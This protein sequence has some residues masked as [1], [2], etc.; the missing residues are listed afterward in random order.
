MTNSQ[1][2]LLEIEPSISDQKIVDFYPNFLSQTE[3]DALL[4]ASQNLEWQQNSIKMFGKPILN[5]RLEA[6]YGDNGCD[7]SYSG[8][9]LSVSPWVDCLKDL[10]DRIELFTG[11]QYHI[12]I[13]NRYRDGKDSIGWHS[14]KQSSL[15]L[16]PAI[17]SI[18]LGVTRKFSVKP[19]QGGEVQHF[20]LEHG[21]LILMHSGCQTTHVHQV[22]KQLKVT[23]ERIN[24]TF[25]PHINGQH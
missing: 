25:R 23:E 8:V 18:S 24:W 6:I 17:A 10:R 9:L 20:D 4:I 12:V 2:S 13:G 22:P 15:G 5:P 3:A 21:S 11:Y 19:R 7:Y 16:N 1:L 14:D